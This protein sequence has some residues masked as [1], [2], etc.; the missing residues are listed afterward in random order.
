M[1]FFFIKIVLKYIKT[2]KNGKI[3]KFFIKKLARKNKMLYNYIRMFY[4]LEKET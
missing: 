1:H 4:F 2:K 3:S